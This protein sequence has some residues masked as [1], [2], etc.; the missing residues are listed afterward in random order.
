MPRVRF[1][2]RGSKSFSPRKRASHFNGRIRYWPEVEGNP[3]LLGFAG[4]KAGMTHIFYVEDREKVPEFGQEVKSPATVI[5]APPMLI[6]AV[7]VYDETHNGLKTLTEMWA[8]EIPTGV[9]KTIKTLRKGASDEEPE[10]LATIIDKV[11]EVRVLAAT[12]PILT[13]LSKNRTDLI[14]IAVGGGSVQERLEYAKSILGKQVKASEVFKPG[15][16]IDIAGVTKGRGFQG[17]VKRWG[18]RIQQNKSRK[19]IR[20][21]AVINPA[22]PRTIHPN[23][24]RAGQTGYHH[25]TEI[26]KRI[27]MLGSDG[28]RL[29]PEGGFTRYGHV[30]GDYIVLRGSV[31]GPAKRLI[32]IRK[33]VRE[34]K[35]P[36]EAPR[37]TYLNTE[38]KKE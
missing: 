11:K 16:S 28:E 4:Y 21:I 6:C 9:S 31:M 2:R 29:T 25:R 32:R 17:P 26:N 7:R 27:M 15:E 1:P 10:R 8:K 3:Q 19:T 38:W 35:L 33:L 5:D 14:E 22:S 36:T 13:S 34:A 23:V 20:G 37:V 12:Q 18:V 24:P 30:K